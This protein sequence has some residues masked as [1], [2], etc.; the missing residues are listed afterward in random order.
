MKQIV[1]FNIVDTEQPDSHP[2][3]SQRTS[4]PEY[5]SPTPVTHLLIHPQTT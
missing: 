5:W 3:Q 4:S 2:N 1:Y